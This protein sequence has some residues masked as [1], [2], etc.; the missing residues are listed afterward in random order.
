MRDKPQNFIVFKRIFFCFGFNA[1][2]CKEEND[3]D[4]P[5]RIDKH[6]L[7]K[8]FARAINNNNNNNSNNNNIIKY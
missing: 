5:A 7:F 2:A 1:F 6:D 4:L 3:F 8:T